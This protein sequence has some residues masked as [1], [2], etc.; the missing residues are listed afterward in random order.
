MMTFISVR[1]E[2]ETVREELEISAVAAFE[3]HDWTVQ[4]DESEAPEVNTSRPEA[5]GRPFELEEE[6]LG[7]PP[8]PDE[9]D[10]W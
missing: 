9:D 10:G 2:M 6:L 4:S 8:T 7:G 5:E 1:E 3:S